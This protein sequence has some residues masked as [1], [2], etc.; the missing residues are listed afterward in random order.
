MSRKVIDLYLD[1]PADNLYLNRLSMYCLGD[2]PHTRNGYRRYFQGN[3]AKTIGFT[4]EELDRIVA[5]QGE[6]PLNRQFPSALS[7]TK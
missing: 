1:L 7:S 6:K 3:E 2:G 4:L 5:E